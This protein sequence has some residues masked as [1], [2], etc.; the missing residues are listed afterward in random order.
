MSKRPDGEGKTLLINAALGLFATEGVDAVS[1]RA[2]NRAAGLGPA[3]VHYHFSTK[4]ALIDEV[5]HLYGDEVVASI[6]RRSNELNEATDR[7]D[8]EQL[9]R[10]IVNAYL[11]LLDSRGRD[12]ANWIRLVNQYLSSDVDRV[13]NETAELAIAESVQHAYPTVPT[14][15][16]QRA[17]A[18]SIGVFVREL[19]NL[20]E[21]L[22]ST[23]PDS[24]DRAAAHI[25]FL[26]H[27][28]A[29]G[30]SASLDTSNIA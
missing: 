21:D 18:L 20:T 3:S 10:V 24:R 28:L 14:V 26:V 12:G 5:L 30:I 9:I 4:D 27:F 16:I 29:G 6:L 23:N 8:P 25:E 11:E 2:V 22:L 19:A 17:L 15:D 13:T 1:I 7:P